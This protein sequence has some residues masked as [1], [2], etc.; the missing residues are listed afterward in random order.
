MSSIVIIGAGVVGLTTALTFREKGH[1]VRVVAAAKGQETTSAVAG[2]VWYPFR[3][4]PPARVKAW[5]LRS[6]EWF[7]GL[8][9]D[10]PSAGVDVLTRYELVDDERVPWWAEGLPDLKFLKGGFR[11]ATRFAFSHIAP[12]AES[13][14]HLAWLEAKLAHPIT[15][16]R[17]ASF[18]EA[19]AAVGAGPGATVVNC[20]GMGAATLAN[21][22][23]MQAVYGQIVVTE[24]G[25]IDLRESHDDE[26]DLEKLFYSI[27]RRSEVVLGGC[28]EACAA[29]RPTTTTAAMTEAILARTRA[30][31]L[32]PGRVIRE[33]AGLRPYRTSGVRVERDASDPRVIHN[34]GHGGAGFTLARGCAEEVCAMVDKT[35]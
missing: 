10:D 8:A 29:D 2:A 7:I 20:T 22:R 23:A 1:E 4:D 18:D 21:D 12:R 9:R 34:Y 25:D 13:A 11:G 16:R 19:R 24:P 32:N 3:A 30:H 35:L 27:P 14:I 17:V 6:R 31:G 15:L 33:R 28:A 5:A 26:R